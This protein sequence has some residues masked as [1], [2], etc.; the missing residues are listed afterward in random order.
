MLCEEDGFL[1]VVCEEKVFYSCLLHVAFCFLYVEKQGVLLVLRTSFWKSGESTFQASKK[2]SFHSL[3]VSFKF[4][5]STSK[6]FSL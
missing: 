5:H 3:F 4:H 6:N 2:H 1:L